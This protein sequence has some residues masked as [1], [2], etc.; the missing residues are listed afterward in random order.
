MLQREKCFHTKK[1]FLTEDCTL[2]S[3]EISCNWLPR[4][5]TLA[6]QLLIVKRAPVIRIWVIIT[7]TQF[8]VWISTHWGR[9]THLC[10]GDIAI[11]GSDNSW[12]PIRRQA[13]LKTNA[14]ILLIVPQGTNFS[15]ILNEIHTFS[16][17]K[18]HLNGSSAT[19]RC[20][21]LLQ[22]TRIKQ[23]LLSN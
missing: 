21:A 14:G 19:W 18:M 5:P 6:W 8:W 10:V 17:I 20:H 15:D 12:S 2:F 13:I 16:F 4:L 7:N 11:I 3:A 9:V 1:W 22:K 23:Q